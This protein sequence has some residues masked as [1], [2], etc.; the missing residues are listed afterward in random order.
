MSD[1]WGSATGIGDNYKNDE[2]DEGPETE[3]EPDNTENTSTPSETAD[4]D[5]TS[6]TSSTCQ[7]KTRNKTQCQNEAQEHSEYC[8]KHAPNA[9]GELTW[10][11]ERVQLYM[12]EETRND[13]F[14]LKTRLTMD[15]DSLKID[16]VSKKAYSQ[17]IMELITE[18]EVVQERLAERLN[19][20]YSE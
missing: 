20:K 18:D 12:R 2:P 8:Q 1:G 7:A 4:P 3:N 13:L 17:T 11:F 19:E 10:T 5:P 6:S 14:E 15:S 9:A 16:S